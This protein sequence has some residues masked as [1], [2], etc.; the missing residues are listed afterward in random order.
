[1][2][3]AATF[4]IEIIAALTMP[5]SF[6]AVVW[7]RIKSEMG[8]GYRSL[9][10]L[11]IGVVTPIVLILG[12]ENKISGEAISALIG[13]VFAYLFTTASKEAK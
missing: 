12:L 7:H 13:G 4:W 10:F 5:L 6:V 1:M 9:Q 8:M 2:D 3:P 11:A